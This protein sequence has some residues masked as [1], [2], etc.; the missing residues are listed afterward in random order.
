MKRLSECFEIKYKIN[1]NDL[2]VN[3]FVCKKEIINSDG[4]PR[5]EF[6]VS[7]NEFFYTDYFLRLQFY[8]PICL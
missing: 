8:K 4:I 5:A 6:R 2:P 1:K 7:K 3:F